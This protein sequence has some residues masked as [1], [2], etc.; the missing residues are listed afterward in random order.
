MNQNAS[1]WQH[2]NV[3][4]LNTATACIST[5][6]QD[7]KKVLARLFQDSKVFSSLVSFLSQALAH[8]L[9]SVTMQLRQPFPHCYQQREDVLWTGP[10]PRMSHADWYWIRWSASS[11]WTVCKMPSWPIILL[12]IQCKKHAID[13][14]PFSIYFRKSVSYKHKLWNIHRSRSLFSHCI[15]YCF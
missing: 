3:C 4:F 5:P 1:L 7:C 14:S 12:N 13:L 6:R 2:V 10:N 11:T 8:E 15:T 9:S